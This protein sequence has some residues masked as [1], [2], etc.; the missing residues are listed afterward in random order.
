MAIEYPHRIF[1]VT[2][3]GDTMYFQAW[4]QNDAESKLEAVVG[5]IPKRLL[6]WSEVDQ[7]PEGEDLT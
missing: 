5:H 7:L 3:M 4:D 1:K 6:K 2:A